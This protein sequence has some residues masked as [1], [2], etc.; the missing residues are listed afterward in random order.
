MGRLCIYRSSGVVISVGIVGDTQ[1]CRFWETYTARVTKVLNGYTKG[2]SSPVCADWQTHPK[3]LNCSAK[4][5][6][7]GVF[8][9]LFNFRHGVCVEIGNLPLGN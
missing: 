2:A 8:E 5:S 6:F 7:S 9:W 3:P 1:E 4:A